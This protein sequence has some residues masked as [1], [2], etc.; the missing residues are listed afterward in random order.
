[1]GYRFDDDTAVSLVE[2]GRYSVHLHKDWS[3]GNAL[4]G[5]YVLSV[6]ARA[7]MADDPHPDLLGVAANFTRR[8]E[9]GPAEARVERTREGRRVG[10][11]RVSL[12]QD[13]SVVLDAVLTSGTLAAGEPAW[14]QLSDVDLVP[15]DFPPDGSAWG[16]FRPPMRG[17]RDVYL[18]P[19]MPFL[20]GDLGGP[21]VMSGWLR[22]SDGRDADGLA[23][24]YLCD[25]LPPVTFAQGRSG[26]VPTI[27]L[28]LMIRAHPA[29]GPVWVTM[30]GGVETGGFLDEQFQVWDSTRRLVAHG[31][32]L[33]GSPRR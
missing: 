26:W 4:H 11:S 18:D 32:Q 13:G 24:P 30:R 27:Q 5:G 16:D 19:R 10:F 28:S 31:Y 17:L 15:P 2:T 21:P 29:P 33:A 20:S 7:A 14:S 25:A 12:V 23:M 6:A 9:P 22:F 8:A 1:M 3:I